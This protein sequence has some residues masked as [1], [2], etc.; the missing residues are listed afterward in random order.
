LKGFII[1]M[2]LF[3]AGGFVLLTQYGEISEAIIGKMRVEEGKRE[4][5]EAAAL[6]TS[7]QPAA[8][9]AKYQPYL[10][11]RW[12]LGLGAIYLDE[13][14]FLS[15]SKETLDLYA[16]TPLDMSKPYANFMFE[17]AKRIELT[18]NPV[19]INEAYA[20]YKAHREKF[21]NDE[22]AKLVINAIS[23]MITKYGMI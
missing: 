5:I 14:W 6:K 16:G 17:R 8:F 11:R 1:T 23:R 21:P 19:L 2:V 7:D 18:G 22:H 10:D 15:L 4:S 3:V 20:L 13:N 12:T 9:I